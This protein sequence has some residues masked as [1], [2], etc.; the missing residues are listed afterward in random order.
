MTTTTTPVT[1]LDEN[2][3]DFDSSRQ[4]LS[5]HIEIRASGRIEAGRLRSA[6][7]SATQLHPMAR[8][9][10]G[11]A[12]LTSKTRSWEITPE[13]E[14]DPLTV[15]AAETP[16]ELQYAREQLVSVRVPLEG[17]PPFRAYLVHYAGGD[18]LILNVNHAAGDGIG[19]VSL[20][21][22]IM[23]AYADERDDGGS[24]DPLAARDASTILQLDDD[25][26]RKERL[27]NLLSEAGQFIGKLAPIEPAG[28][29]NRA[30]YGL[31]YL[32]LDPEETARLKPKRHVAGSVNDL[33]VAAMHLSIERWN[34]DHDG[35][36]GNCRVMIPVNLRPR[37][38]WHEVFCNYSLAFPTNSNARQRKTPQKL[39]RAIVQRTTTAKE[40]GFATVFLEPLALR[41]KMPLWLKRYL[42]PS[43]DS[44]H[45]INVVLSNVGNLKER[46]SLGDAGAVTEFWFSPPMPMSDGL[47]MGANGYQGALHL[48]FRYVHTLM[49]EDAISDFADIYRQSLHWLSE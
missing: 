35:Q 8:A 46:F 10:L 17:S 19:T 14:F 37:E 11:P 29:S 40:K 49:S 23:R 32:Y 28:G 34:A 36:I 6:I 38:W 24:I 43:L 25:E 41:A 42:V 26:Q 5:V 16:E 21:Q 30:G 31:H 18:Y 47:S 9:R 4:P 48:C 44:A 3:I 20:M 15:V 1:L 39:M 12:A 2:F 27:N 45:Q 33:L 7:R 22:S 13:L